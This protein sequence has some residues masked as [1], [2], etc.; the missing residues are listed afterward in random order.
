M[1]SLYSNLIVR[2]NLTQMILENIFAKNDHRE[3]IYLISGAFCGG[4]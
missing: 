4:A 2:T 3:V 1:F